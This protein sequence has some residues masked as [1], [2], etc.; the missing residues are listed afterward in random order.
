MPGTGP[1]RVRARVAVDSGAWCQAPSAGLVRKDGPSRA[2]EDAGARHRALV[3]SRSG[4]R[5]FGARCLAP[6]TGERLECG[7]GCRR[8]LAPGG[9]AAGMTRPTAGGAWHRLDSVRAARMGRRGRA[10]ALDLGDG[11][12]YLCRVHKFGATNEIVALRAPLSRGALHCVICA[13][14]RSIAIRALVAGFSQSG[15]AVSAGA[16]QAITPA[17]DAPGRVAARCPTRRADRQGG[18]SAPARPAE[19]HV[20]AA[21]SERQPKAPNAANYDESKANPYPTCPTRWS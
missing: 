17:P 13:F 14:L 7:A 4:R 1:S 12:A 20:A 11:H 2:K 18:S 8:C 6:W 21:G 3:G 16:A 10:M 9:R 5:R 15:R 19:D